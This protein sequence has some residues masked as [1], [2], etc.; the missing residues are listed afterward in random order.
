MNVTHSCLPVQRGDC[1][2][3]PCAP[4]EED[5]RM[6]PP[7]APQSLVF[8]LFFG[9]AAGIFVLN[10]GAEA[11]LQASQSGIRLTSILLAM[12]NT[13]IVI[14]SLALTTFGQFVATEITKIPR[15]FNLPQFLVFFALPAVVF[16]LNVAALATLGASS[17]EIRVT[18]ILVSMVNAVIV[19]SLVL[20][21]IATKIPRRF[22]SPQFLKLFG[23][24]NLV[25]SA[26]ALAILRAS[27]S[28]FGVTRIFV[29]IIITIFTY[30]VAVFAL[31]WLLQKCP[32]VFLGIDQNKKTEESDT[33]EEEYSNVV[34]CVVGH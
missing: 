34:E 7:N 19:T 27:P 9:L 24:A 4:N 3:Q 2:H 22:S 20:V 15:R 29:S 12:V 5:V 28:E 31:L 6:F 16:F 30:Y 18:C 25:V 10:V 1:H 23:L 8:F 26:A 33:T 14:T 32:C 21:A 13:V 11:I 17:S